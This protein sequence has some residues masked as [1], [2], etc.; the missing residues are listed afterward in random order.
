M[1]AAVAAVAEELRNLQK[2]DGGFDVDVDVDSDANVLQYATL[3][4]NEREN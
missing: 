1:F 3:A 4:A 2:S